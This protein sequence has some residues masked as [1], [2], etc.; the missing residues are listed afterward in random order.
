[1]RVS[2]AIFAAIVKDAQENYLDGF[3]IDFKQYKKPKYFIMYDSF[4]DITWTH[5]KS[6]RE[7]IL[8][9]VY[10][11]ESTGKILQAGTNYGALSL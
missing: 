3:G 10:W 7:L 4:M 11:N 5:K 6:G 1:M 9:R 2:K 8:Y